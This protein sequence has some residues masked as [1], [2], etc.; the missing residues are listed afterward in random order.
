MAG[1][2]K[3]CH[4]RALHKLEI[5]GSGVSLNR[6]ILLEV[7]HL[8]GKIRNAGVLENGILEFRSTAGP[9]GIYF[10]IPVFVKLGLDSETGTAH[11]HTVSD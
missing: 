4:H 10:T 3:R 5:T 8:D 1:W 6:E 7:T 11:A 9:V 2:S